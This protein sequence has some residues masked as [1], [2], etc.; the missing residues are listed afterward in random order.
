M[1]AGNPLNSFKT[2]GSE[3]QPRSFPQSALKGVDLMPQI[4]INNQFGGLDILAKEILFPSFGT[5]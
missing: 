3:R 1:D 2:H 5:F 4:Y